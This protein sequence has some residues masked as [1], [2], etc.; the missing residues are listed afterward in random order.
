M[1]TQSTLQK[2]KREKILYDERIQQQGKMYEKR[3]AA[4][5]AADKKAADKKAADK[6]AADKKAAA[7]KLA[8]ETYWNNTQGKVRTRQAARNKK[9]KESK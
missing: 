1:N 8:A 3:L 4:K 2:G 5:K 9:L 7:K 6:K